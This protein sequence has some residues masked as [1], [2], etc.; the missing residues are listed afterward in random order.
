MNNN[1]IHTKFNFD[2]RQI[3]TDPILTNNYITI[4]GIDYFIYPVSRVNSAFEKNKGAH[5]FVFALYPQQEYDEE[6]NPDPVKVLKVSNVFDASEEYNN[7]N[8]KRFYR[9]I[10][11]LWE[12]KKQRIRNIVEIDMSGFFVCINRF[13]FK[14]QVKER[15]VYFPYYMM[16]YAK[17]DLKQYLETNDIDEKSKLD[18]CLQIAYG[19]KDLD[20]LGFYHRD[21][22]PDNILIFNDNQWRISD[23]GLVAKRDE[24]IDRP[25]EFIGPKGWISPEAMNKYL[26]KKPNKKINTLIDHQSD[27]FQLG[28]VFWYILQGNA[29]IGCI[30]EADFH[31]NN[32]A[33][34]SIIRQMLNYSKKHRTKS[35]DIVIKEL[36]MVIDKYYH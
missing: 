16:D 2:G 6:V 26:V 9:E 35:I 34:Y 14:N 8:N 17:C 21:I 22:K 27:L 20:S 36:S 11:A 4:N 18:L 13:K 19:I 24:D 28:K 29:P 12:C 10:G 25:N 7:P 1:N 15:F 30:R 3:V 23:L 31:M 32:S 33:L 5:S